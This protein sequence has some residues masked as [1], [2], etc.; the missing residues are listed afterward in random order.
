V[1]ERERERER[2]EQREGEGEVV[3][4]QKSA[5]FCIQGCITNYISVGTT[6]FGDFPTTYVRDNYDSPCL[7]LLFALRTQ[8]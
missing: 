7:S 4:G 3:K 5:F 2:R 6:D 1:R 8:S